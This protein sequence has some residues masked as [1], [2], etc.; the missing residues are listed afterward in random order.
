MIY[1]KN[2]LEYAAPFA[3]ALANDRA[4]R[5]WVL[6][7][8]FAC[9]AND[10]RPLQEEMKKRRSASAKTW[11]QSHFTEACR[12]AA[13]AAKRLIYSRYSKWPDLD[14]PCTSKSKN[15]TTE[16]RRMETSPR[17]T[18]FRPYAGP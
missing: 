13:A 18:L 10:A 17:R 12:C 4:F 2:E 7:T 11:W 1:G 9:F 5:I 16:S 3:N 6:Q 15:P 8:E 14:L